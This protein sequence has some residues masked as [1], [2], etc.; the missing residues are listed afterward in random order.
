[1]SADSTLQNFFVAA[2]VTAVVVAAVVVAVDVLQ[3]VAVAVVVVAA[4]DI[5]I[6]FALAEPASGER[7][8]ILPLAFAIT[9]EETFVRHQFVCFAVGSVTFFDWM[10]CTGWPSTTG[11]EDFG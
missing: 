2:V 8:S 10:G 11:P 9:D 5:K 3:A 1:M 6:D 4:A 7:E